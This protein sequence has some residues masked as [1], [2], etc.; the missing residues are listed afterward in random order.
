[1]SET[2]EFYRQRSKLWFNKAKWNYL[3]FYNIYRNRGVRKLVIPDGITRQKGLKKEIQVTVLSS[4]I[5]FKNL[6]NTKHI[7]QSYC[8]LFYTAVKHSLLNE[9]MQAKPQEG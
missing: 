6:K 8:L 3:A 4:R 2:A 7:K 9:G 5:L 1:M